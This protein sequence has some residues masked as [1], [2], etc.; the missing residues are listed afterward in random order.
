MTVGTNKP[1]T[2]PEQ[3]KVMVTVERPSS[4]DLAHY[5]RAEKYQ[6]LREN[7]A[8]FRETL[9]AFLEE[10]GLSKEVS[11]IGEPT[12][13]NLLFVVC[14][15][16]VAEQLVQVPGVVSVSP[17]KEFDVDLLWPTDKTRHSL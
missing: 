13:F 15:P 14:T 2:S 7:T 11:Y 8:R 4:E 6:I 9:I 12:A 17:S 1:N 10:Q 16:Q 5:N 3:I